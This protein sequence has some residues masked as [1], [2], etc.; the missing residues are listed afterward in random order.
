MHVLGR[1]LLR[2]AAMAGRGLKHLPNATAF[3]GAGV[4]CLQRNATP[5]FAALSGHHD[6]GGK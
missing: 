5:S 6:D 1:Q 4:R 2:R 3:S